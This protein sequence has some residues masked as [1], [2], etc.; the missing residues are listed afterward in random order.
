LTLV[1]GQ[2]RDGIDLNY[3]DQVRSAEAA[4]ATASVVD[5][6][7]GVHDQS[8]RRVG[9]PVG[10][11]HNIPEKA[12]V[13]RTVFRNVIRYVFRNPVPSTYTGSRMIHAAVSATDDLD[14]GAFVC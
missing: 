8:I 4:E 7:H 6:V 9:Q 2:V 14:R 5:D 3:A 1:G 13:F 11:A 12:S 10:Q